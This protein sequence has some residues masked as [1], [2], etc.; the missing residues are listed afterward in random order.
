MEKGFDVII[1]NLR[2]N[3]NIKTKD[4]LKYFITIG[5]K[6]DYSEAILSLS[7]IELLILDAYTKKDLRSNEIFK[8]T[9]VIKK[10]GRVMIV[11]STFNISEYEILYT[12]Y[13]NEMILSK[14]LSFS[15][16]E[17]DKIE[18]IKSYYMIGD[19]FLSDVSNLEYELDKTSPIRFFSGLYTYTNFYTLGNKHIEG[20]E[21]NIFAILHNL[22]EKSISNIDNNLLIFIYTLNLIRKTGSNTRY[23]ELNYKQISLEYCFNFLKNKI[24]KYNLTLKYNIQD[25]S[26]SFKIA[27]LIKTKYLELMNNKSFYRK[28]NGLT[29]TGEEHT[30]DTNFKTDF[31]PELLTIIQR[32]LTSYNINLSSLEEN[33]KELFEKYLFKHIDNKFNSIAE[34]IIH[35]IMEKGLE[36][37][38]SDFAT[39]RTIHNWSGL[40]EATE[41]YTKYNSMDKI[42]NFKSTN[43]LGYAIPSKILQKKMPLSI[44]SQALLAISTRMKV[45]G[46]HYFLGNFTRKEN[47]DKW[48]YFPP[49]YIEKSTYDNYY[50][51]GHIK[52]NI[53]TSLR[54][55]KELKIKNKVYQGLIDFRVARQNDNEYTTRELILNNNIASLLQIIYQNLI[56]VIEKNNINYKF[57]IGTKEWYKLFYENFN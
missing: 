7:S 24:L 21:I 11:D 52:F 14:E 36:L 34:Q 47:Q 30:F 31:N 15:K 44:I 55:S 27:D 43:F 13:L 12:F 35:E 42:L 19:N 38:K 3:N 45:N 29:L 48:F 10:Y 54:S 41:E 39:S 9:V 25:I 22:K 49:T 4:L 53:N 1:K 8:Y 2:N 17:F 6:I 33:L 5:Y 16:N 57:T 40:I 56:E 50:H 23:E 28:I 37:L 18:Y 20:Y 32:Y 26:D 46:S 51:T